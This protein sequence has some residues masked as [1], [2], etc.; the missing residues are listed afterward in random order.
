[1]SKAFDRVEWHFVAQ[2]MLKM[3]F[4][5]TV[6]QLILRCLQSVSY[7]FLLNGVV[8][9]DMVPS[10]GIRQGDPLLLYLFLICVEGL[11]CLLQHEESI[12]SLQGLKVSRSAPSVSHLF[13]ADDSIL[14]CRASQQSTM[15]IKRSLDLYSKA[16]G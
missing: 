2:V 5:I 15:S 1:M 3:G 12:G 4:I 13:F 16:S 8:H 14:F 7:L 10:R 6:E 11:S 9:G